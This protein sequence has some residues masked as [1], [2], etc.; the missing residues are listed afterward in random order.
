ME[1]PDLNIL[2]QKSIH[3][4]RIRTAAG[5]RHRPVSHAVNRMRI[6][7]GNA[8]MAIGARI[9]A[10]PGPVNPQPS[11]GGMPIAARTRRA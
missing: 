4:D 9:A 7:A 2:I 3:N 10:S 11:L 1:H 5:M 8:L 6:I